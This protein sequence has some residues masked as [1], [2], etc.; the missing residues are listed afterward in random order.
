M[1]SCVSEKMCI[2]CGGC[3]NKCPHQAITMKW[4]KKGFS[5]PVIDEKKC[6]GCNLCEQVCPV[7]HPAAPKKILKLIGGYYADKEIVSKSSSGGAFYLFASYIIANKGIVV[8]VVWNEEFLPVHKAIDNIDDLEAMHGSK[9]VQSDKRDI[10]ACIEKYLKQ[11]KMVLFSGTPCECLAVKKYLGREY[12]NLYL[13]EFI[14]HGIPSPIIWKEYLE[15]LYNEKKIIPTEIN[16]R[17]KER[18]GWHGYELKISHEEQNYYFPLRQ[19]LFFNGFTENLFLR[20]SCYNCSCKCFKTAAD[21][22]V[23]DFWGSEKYSPTLDDRNGKNGLSLVACFS[24]KGI[25]LLEKACNKGNFIYEILNS[26]KAYTSNS[27]SMFQATRN[28]NTDKF[29]KYRESKGT[30]EALNKY[31]RYTFKKKLCNKVIWKIRAF[32]EK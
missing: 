20:E 30:I 1:I 6:T 32:L 22:S 21:I 15:N 26:D 31:A 16:F 7:L 5:Y 18:N 8:G 29:Y 14:C 19:D 13:L 28:K 24:D 17:S 25:N 23:A 2:G 4:D 3:H 27:A 11:G 9:Y 10:Y 12:N